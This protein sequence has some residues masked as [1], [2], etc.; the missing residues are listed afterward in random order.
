MSANCNFDIILQQPLAVFSVTS[1]ANNVVLARSR[2]IGFTSHSYFVMPNSFFKNDFITA[3]A[4][5]T[6]TEFFKISDEQP[7]PIAAPIA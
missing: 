6:Y 5:L 4:K 1:L 3:T 2:C 7:Q